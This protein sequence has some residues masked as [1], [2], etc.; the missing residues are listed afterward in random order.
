M[1]RRA[2]VCIGLGFFFA[3]AGIRAG[4][5]GGIQ[6]FATDTSLHPLAGVSVSVTAPSAHAVTTT[7]NDGF[8]SFNGL[9]LDTYTVIFSK[10][11][12][13]TESVAGATVIQ[14]Q[15]LQVNAQLKHRVLTIAN[16]TARS[17]TSL[18]QPAITA[19][20]YVV[21][22]G[23]LSD[24]NGTPQDPN[25]FQA[26]YSLPGVTGV[27]SNNGGTG[28]GSPPAIRGG[29][30]TE[31]GWQYDGIDNV[32]QTFRYPLNYPVALNGVQSIQLTTGGYSVGEGNTNT[33]VVNEVI[34]RGTYPANAQLTLRADDPIYGHALSFDYGGATP[35]NRF[36]YYFGF[37]GQHDAVG[38]GDL[39]TL[40][41]LQ[42]GNW[43]F[44]VL[45][46]S[47][48]NL[49]YHLG[50]DDRSELQFLGSVT[51]FHGPVNYL[52]NPAIAPY[53]S[54]NGN[55]W[56]A[57]DKF[58]LQSFPTYQSSYATLYPGQTAYREFTASP[59]NWTNNSVIEKLNFK[60]QLTPSSFLDLRLF[61]TSDN[62]VGHLPY[63][64]GSFTDFYQD[65][66]STAWGAAVD[67]TGQIDTKNQL[68]LGAQ[69][70]SY[71]NQWMTGTPSLEPFVEPLEA[72]GCPQAARALPRKKKPRGGCYIA[73]F[74][75]ALN[76]NLNLGLP[77]DPAYAPMETYA[78]DFSYANDPL[79]RWDAY[80]QDRFQPTQRL[81]ATL[82]LRWDKEAIPLPANAADLNMSYH[83]AH[84]TYGNVVTVPGQPIGNDVT[85]PSQISPRLGMSYELTSRDVVRF[86]Y[87]K[88]IEFVALSY[89]EDTY[90]VP[91]SLQRCSIANHC[92]L[93][94]PGYGRTN[95]V[96]NLYQQ[97]LLDLNTNNFAQ[98]TPLL[99]QKAVNLE[100][101]YDHDFGRG[102]EMRVT[103]YYRK[104]TDYLVTNQPVLFTL[105]SGTPVFG[106]PR[107]E[108]GGINVNTGVEFTLQRNAP[109][110]ISGLLDLTYVNTLANYDYGTLA[111]NNPARLAS[112]Q[113]FHVTYV[114]PLQ[115]TL[116]LVY[117]TRTG[118]HFATTVLYECCY[119]YG[120]GT[121]TWVFGPN[122]PVQ[123]PNTNLASGS[124]SGAYYLTNPSDPGTK[125]APHIVASRGTPEG[126]DPGTLFGPAIT[127][128]GL[129]LSQEFRTGANKVEVGIRAVNLIGNY[130]PYVIPANPY[131]GFSG[132]G[133]YG[134]PSGVNTNAC[135]PGQTF[136]CEPFRYNYS[137]FPYE[138][139]PSGQPRVYT[140]FINFKL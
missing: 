96:T 68:S 51:N 88:Q 44:T 6:G 50:N 16:V 84:G 24:I 53:A 10:D 113:M 13:L 32:I 25:G 104:G 2:V 139:E 36:S 66:Q 41:P 124:A 38:Y 72:L 56:A 21:T 89:L 105:K 109:L 94:L 39:H 30:D 92:F 19:D 135:A 76:A 87:G 35:N 37:A 28:G 131:Y 52:I 93:P 99:P 62:V 98:Y 70:I 73:P 27:N 49:I 4:T 103:P 80:V 108:S 57:T 110:G 121:M 17:S 8:Y 12:Y 18:V 58:G 117:N 63:N 95:H 60:R 116:N 45:N 67:Y 20:T 128:V 118:L 111:T 34:K 61:H 31:T 138:N 134:H 83:L 26:L 69:G 90:Q 64:S 119:R 114:A 14:D 47:V 102:L 130:S 3:T 22:Q 112:G 78:S 129:T 85:Q 59:D 127:T 125:L 97:I 77:T 65:T 132:I 1:V 23:R 33:G 81:T 120:V 79:H 71:K 54:N 137:P 75:A 40:L 107:N 123:V 9:P 100:F 115:G 106:A 122:G 101:S 133:N 11:R 74:N 7:G 86:S 136:G 15:S 46:D 91:S 55:V 29:L 42:L 43:V 140:F 48:L 126:A 82:G 5:V